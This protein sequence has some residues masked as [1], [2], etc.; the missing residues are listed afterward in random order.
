MTQKALTP[1]RPTRQLPADKGQPHRF[2]RWIAPAV[3]AMLALAV[4][5]TAGLQAPMPAQAHEEE[6]H[7][8]VCTSPPAASCPTYDDVQADPT[9]LST[10]MTVGSTIRTVSTV[11]L[12][13]VGYSPEAGSLGS[14]YFKYRGTWYSV[15]LLR[16]QRDGI[17]DFLVLGIDPSF[18]STFHPELALELDGQR[19]LLSNAIRDQNDFTWFGNLPAWA[20]NDSV[21]VKLTEPPTPNAY[22]YRTIWTALMT[23]EPNPSDATRYIGYYIDSY[24]EI[25]NNIIVDGRDETV[26]IGTV[27]QPRFPWTGFEITNTVEDTTSSDISFD[28]DSESYPSDEEVAGWTLVV[29]GKKLP[30]AEATNVHATFPHRWIFDYAP[31]WTAGQQVVVSIR[32]KEVQNRYGQVALK[33]RRTT[34]TDGNN[35]IIYGKTHY[36]YARGSSRFGQADSWELQHLQVTTDKTGDTDPVWITATFRAPND[37]VSWQGYWEGQFDE[38]HTLFIRWIYQVDGIGKGAVTYTLPLRAAAT[39]GGIQRSRS[40]REVSFTWMRTYK[41]FQ[42]RHLDLGNHSTISA[43]MLAPPPPATARSTVTIQNTGSQHGLYTPAPTVTSAEF[44]SNPGDDQTYG[45]GDVIQATLTFDQEVTVRY[46]DSK[47]QA[48]PAWSWR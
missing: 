39:E 17:T 47:R 5:L 35:N 28:F 33:A 3:L 21:S 13:R 6:G 7:T 27:D 44:T 38:F 19:Y 12:H 10:T 23:A 20:E 45:P 34:R 25:T 46:A 14:T 30:F 43:D 16:T 4:I 18:P 31:G 8:H 48:Q 1:G 24:G 2:G 22:G 11:T 42:R 40:G 15:D 9:F 36:T 37:S 29:D 32:T 26:T 41:E